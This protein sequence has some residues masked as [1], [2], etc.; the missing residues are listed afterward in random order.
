MRNADFLRF[1]MGQV[2]MIVAIAIVPVMIIYLLMSKFIVRGV[3][4]GS[5]K[6]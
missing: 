2:Y 5:V 3:A 6:G 1:D 4:V